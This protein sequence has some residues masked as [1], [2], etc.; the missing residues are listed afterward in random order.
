MT[1]EG[2]FKILHIEV[3]NCSFEI[4]PA[5]VRD[6]K[7]IRFPASDFVIPALRD[8]V[9]QAHATVWTDDIVQAY[10]KSR[11]GDIVASYNDQTL[12]DDQFARI[13]AAVPDLE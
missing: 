1:Y 13:L 7:W 11:E 3:D 2:P 5:L 9:N 8:A 10:Q 4:P 6:N 12:T